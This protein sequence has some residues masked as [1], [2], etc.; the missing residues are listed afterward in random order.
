MYTS[1]ARPRSDNTSIWHKR[2]QGVDSNAQDPVSMLPC[3]EH[4]VKRGTVVGSTAAQT[5]KGGI[6]KGE[7]CELLSGLHCACGLYMVLHGLYM[8][9]ARA[10]AHI[11]DLNNGVVSPKRR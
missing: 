8:P 6:S 11:S 9:M 1:R 4:N 3:G 2:L 5:P 7:L 10:Q